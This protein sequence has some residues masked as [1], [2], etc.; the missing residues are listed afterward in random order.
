MYLKQVEVGLMEN[1]N[2]LIGDEA[3]K[4]CVYI[5]P[6]WEVDRILRLAE[7]DGYKVSKILLT[8]HHFDHVEGVEEVVAKTGASVYGHA[9]DLAQV[10]TGSA[11]IV[12]LNEGSAIAI[13]QFS[14][15]AI[16]T[17]G[18]TPGSTCYL[19]HD[20]STGQDHLFTGDT[21]FQAGCGR[22]DLPGGDPAVM[23]HSLQRVK[24]LPPETLVYPGHDYG[25]R[26]ISSIQWEKQKNPYFQYDRVEEFVRYR[27][28]R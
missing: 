9:L 28:G 16:H 3:T 10:K 17:P 26:K 12:P 4:E 25:D 7:E 23:F 19:I 22:C 21:V 8:H 5:D 11:T 15:K 2:Y 14:I 27:M 24:Q 20:A 18:H 13:G 6:A 1:F